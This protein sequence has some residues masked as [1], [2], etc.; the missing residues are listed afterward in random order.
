MSFLQNNLDFFV[1]S[2]DMS[3]SWSEYV[4]DDAFSYYVDEMAEFNDF[5]AFQGTF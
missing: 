1:F 5:R 4:F 3:E 2:L